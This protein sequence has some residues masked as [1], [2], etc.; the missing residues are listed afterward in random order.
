MHCSVRP[1]IR[2]IADV[3]FFR[4]VTIITPN[5]TSWICLFIAVDDSLKMHLMMYFLKSRCM[6]L[7]YICTLEG[8]GSVPQLLPRVSKDRSQVT[9][10]TGR[11]QGSWETDGWT[12]HA[13][14]AVKPSPPYAKRWVLSS[15]AY[16]ANKPSWRNTSMEECPPRQSWEGSLVQLLGLL[17]VELGPREMKSELLR[18]NRDPIPRLVAV[19]QCRLFCLTQHGPRHIRRN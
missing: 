7:S 3:V 14:F 5:N 4:D 8:S 9:S 12:P 11:V 10:H 1:F 13:E 2:Q 16:G 17:G 19:H 6:D 15:E 18:Q